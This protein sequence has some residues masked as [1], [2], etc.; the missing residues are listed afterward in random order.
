[1]SIGGYLAYLAA[2]KGRNIAGVMA[3]T[4]A[5]PRLPI[6]R[7]QFAQSPRL[8]RMLSPFLPAVAA[9]VGGLRLP[10]RWFANM[11]GIANHAEVSRL[12]A[13]DPIGG[14]NRARPRFMHSLLSITPAIEPENFDVCPVLLADPAADRWTTLEASKPSFDRIRGEGPKEFTILENCGHF[15][16]EEPGVS[17]LEQAMVAFLG[18]LPCVT[19]PTAGGH[20]ERAPRTAAS[21][22]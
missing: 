8:N 14:G 18:R 20:Q 22:C 16:M 10:L 19:R 12:L 5:D 7:D 6:V 3:T 17:Q 9:C 4:L 21:P 1:M 11:R 15:P 13:T 2:A